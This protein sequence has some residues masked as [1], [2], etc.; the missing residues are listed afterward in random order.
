MTTRFPA[1]LHN[2]T[3]RRSESFCTSMALAEDHISP[4]DVG[5]LERLDVHI[6]QPPLPRV[7]QQAERA[8]RPSGGGPAPSPQERM[9]EAPVGVGKLRINEQRFH[10]RAPCS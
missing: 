10:S 2:S 9:A 7:G 1:A 5:R 8:K 6:H 3:T 4:L